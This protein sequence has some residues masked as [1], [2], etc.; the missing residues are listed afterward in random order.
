MDCEGNINVIQQTSS[1]RD[2]TAITSIVEIINRVL[3]R[4]NKAE[5]HDIVQRDPSEACPVRQSERYSNFPIIR[6]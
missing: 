3:L 1:V 2:V 4:N 6:I 5:G